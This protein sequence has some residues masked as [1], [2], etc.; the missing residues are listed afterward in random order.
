MLIREQ[1]SKVKATV[2]RLLKNP[3]GN[4]LNISK[5]NRI[6]KLNSFQLDGINLLGFK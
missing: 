4:N 6:M 1:S 5:M 3:Y 2:K